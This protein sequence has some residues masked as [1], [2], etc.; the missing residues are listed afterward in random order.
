MKVYEAPAKVNIFLKITGLRGAYHELYSRFIR[1]QELCDFLWFDQ[2]SGQSFQIEGVPCDR[3][4]N[5]VFKAYKALLEHYPRKEIVEYCKEHKLVIQKKIPIGAGLGGGSSDAATFLLMLNE[6]MNLNIAKEELAA[7][8]GEAGADIPFFVMGY[9]S[10]NVTG[11]GEIVE[12]FDENPPKLELFTPP[13]HCNTGDV[14]RTFR[15][16]FQHRIDKALAE[17]LA[18][19]TSE[20]IL[21]TFDAMV[22]NDLLP[23]ALKC[24]PELYAYHQPGWFFSGSGS[25]F[26]RIAL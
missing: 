22:L 12:R 7:I 4:E 23:A 5:T 6:A 9:K 11:I 15:R 25:T 24:Y 3:S 26:F 14:Y 21:A 8:G 2:G 1:H 19:L 20:E 18:S 17:R 16:Y 10:A 13:I